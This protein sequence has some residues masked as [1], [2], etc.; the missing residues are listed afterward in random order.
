MSSVPI[1]KFK[2]QC[3]A[4]L[5]NVRKTGKPLRVTRFG[6]PIADIVPAAVSAPA[7]W[8]GLFPEGEIHGDLVAPVMAESEWE[9]LAGSPSS[10][11][12]RAR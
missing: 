1:S 7:N 6:K 11:R 9:A 10:S 3:L 2:A 5:E 4:M 12:K 8:L